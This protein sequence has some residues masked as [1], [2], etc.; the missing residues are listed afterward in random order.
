MLSNLMQMNKLIRI[1]QLKY[2]TLKLTLTLEN[3]QQLCIHLTLMPMRRLS[4][5]KQLNKFLFNC[6][7][8]KM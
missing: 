8:R 2:T 4:I 6:V 7:Y 5:S 3:L 1:T